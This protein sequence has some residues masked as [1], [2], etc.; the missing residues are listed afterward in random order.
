MQLWYAPIWTSSGLAV[1]AK[2]RS[3]HTHEDLTL[4]FGL[5]FTVRGGK[6]R[7]GTAQRKEKG[8]HPAP[9]RSRRQVWDKRRS[10]V[11]TDPPAEPKHVSILAHET[12]L[13]LSAVSR[14]HLA[15]PLPVLPLPA[16][17]RR[18]KLSRVTSSHSLCLP[19]Q[20][21]KAGW[22]RSAPSKHRPVSM[23]NYMESCQS[24]TIER[25]VSKLETS[26]AQNP[27]L[28]LSRLVALSM[29]ATFRTAALS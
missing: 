2:S 10:S 7:P 13:L 14:R 15:P 12:Q 9:A 6:G 25:L 19:Y 27:S 29:T 28:S 3:T 18:K 1:L 4:K 26:S 5:R 20:R 17:R 11:P 21:L 8:H 16:I 23:L 22:N 24:T